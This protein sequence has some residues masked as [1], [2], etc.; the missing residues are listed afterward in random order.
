MSE[1]I[2]NMRLTINCCKPYPFALVEEYVRLFLFGVCFLYVCKSLSHEAYVKESSGSGA[3]WV[4][5]GV[6]HG[7]EA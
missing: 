2:D 7:V 3:E 6:L 5:A 1:D 4:V